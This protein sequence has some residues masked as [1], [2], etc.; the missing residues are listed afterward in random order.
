[1]AGGTAIP[2]AIGRAGSQVIVKPAGRC[3]MS[4][5]GDVRRLLESLRPPTTSDVYFDLSE[6]IGID[7]TF[8]G[9]LVSV[10]VRRSDAD[11]PAIHLLSPSEAVLGALRCMHVLPLLHVC[12]EPPGGPVEWQE[13][14]HAHDAAG[15]VRE[16]IVG[17]HESLI[18]A[19]SRNAGAFGRIVAGLREEQRHQE[20]S[21]EP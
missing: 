6:A 19:D 1:M 16:L 7:S 3:T 14:P 12:A 18:E 10:A 9:L 4:I 17:A 20:R 2:V 5:C 21:P 13:L 15:A 11:R 8:T